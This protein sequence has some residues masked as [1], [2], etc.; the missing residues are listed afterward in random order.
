M[1]DLPKIYDPKAVEEKWYRF[2]SEKDYFHPVPGKNKKPFTIMMP[3]PNVT[4]I[5]HMGHALQSTIQDTLTRYHRM[6]GYDALWMPG[7]DHAGIAT[8][9]VVEKMLRERGTS[10]K[11]I[12]R[13]AFLEE[14]WKWKKKH[15]NI[16]SD[17]QK[18]LGS[19]CDWKRERFTMDEGLSQAVRKVFV[20]L[21]EQGLIYKGKYIVNWCPFHMTALSDEEVKHV[22]S[23]GSLW[24][25]K[26]FLDG[27][28]ESI[29]VATTRPETMLGDTAV[30]VN[31]KDKRYKKFIGKKIK[32]PI[33]GRKLPVIA[34]DFV[35]R[36]FGTGA[37]KVT[38]A[39][40]ANDFLMGQRHKLPN[41]IVIDE[42]G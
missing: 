26:Y 8:Q 13:E 7:T 33:L 10:R 31:P 6:R 35:D 36:K 29:T 11:A 14:V 21:Y 2:W 1:A 19:S 34:D 9:N 17:Q 38:P 24:Y 5:L 42:A 32:L 25:I 40:D 18:K 15:G 27:S 30:A 3:P 28:D 4:G 20:T 41:V 23:Q 12:G 37:V 22:E 39:H 16:I